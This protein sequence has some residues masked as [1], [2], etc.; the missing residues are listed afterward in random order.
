MHALQSPATTVMTSA[1]ESASFEAWTRC[2]TAMKDH[3]DARIEAWKEEID[4]ELV[5]VSTYTP[6]RRMSTNL[7][8]CGLP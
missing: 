7:T 1:G 8:Y 4:A 2:A 5:F 6:T 3:E